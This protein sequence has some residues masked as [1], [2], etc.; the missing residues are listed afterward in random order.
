MLI[1]GVKFPLF[2][3]VS[4]LHRTFTEGWETV[5]NDNGISIIIYVYMVIRVRVV[6]KTVT[7]DFTLETY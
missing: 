6:I 7:K 2:S 4:P 5:K 3:L 1:I